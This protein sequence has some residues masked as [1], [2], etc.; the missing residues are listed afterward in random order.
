VLT[1]P[2]T[3]YG[4]DTASYHENAV[5]F[6]LLRDAMI[7]FWDGYLAS[8]ADGADA[9]ASPLPA[10]DLRGLPPALIQTAQ[11]DVLRDGGEAYAARLRRAGVPVRCTRYLAMNHGFALHGASY[12]HARG[13]LEEMAAALREAFGR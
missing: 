8:P 3:N 7:H 4:F 12:E 10:P 5:G 6:G 2:A 11:Y 9:Y 1:Y 13:A